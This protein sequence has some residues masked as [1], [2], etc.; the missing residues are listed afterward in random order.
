MGHW[1][2]SHPK[3]DNSVAPGTRK[4]WP[5]SFAEAAAE[6]AVARK[7]NQDAHAKTEA[8]RRFAN[9]SVRCPSCKVTGP[10]WQIREHAEKKHRDKVFRNS[11]CMIIGGKSAKSTASKDATDTFFE[12]HLGPLHIV[13]EETASFDRLDATRHMGYLARE[14]SRF[15]SHPIHD[16]YDDES[17]A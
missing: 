4:V 17:K 2:I 5:K 1:R 13:K 12:H 8:K 3:R 11:E 15:G 10:R 9:E 6:A 7:I 16:G 14:G